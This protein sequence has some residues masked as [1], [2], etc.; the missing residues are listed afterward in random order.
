MKK[1]LL[2]LVVILCINTVK[3]QDKSFYNLDFGVGMGMNYGGL[4]FNLALAPIPFISVE[5]SY[6]FNFHKSVMGGAVNFHVIPK[7]KM[8]TYGLALKYMYGYNAVL[9]ANGGHMD[10]KTFY[11]SSIG[12]SNKLRFG[13]NK[14]NGID[15]D[16]IIP[17]R[18]DEVDDYHTLLEDEGYEMSGLTPVTISIGYHREF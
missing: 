2:S 5:G 7:N 18:K 3:A 13:N 10:S 14:K 12:I 11:G 4:G 1:V 6:G 8:N 15:I 17:L 16:L 9:I